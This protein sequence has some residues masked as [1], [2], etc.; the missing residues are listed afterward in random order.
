MVRGNFHLTK[1]DAIIMSPFTVLN[2]PLWADIAVRTARILGYA[3][4]ALT[5]VGALVF[6]P[7]SVTPATVII[8]GSMAI[9]GCVCFVAS[10]WQKYVWEWVSLFFLT[11]GIAVYVVGMWLQVGGNHKY[12]ASASIF[13]MLVMLLVVRLVDLTVYW[14]QNVKAAQLS[15]E[16]MQ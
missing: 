5:G 3:F 12:V 13:S 11:G 8:V 16:I 9:F 7:Q 15:K 4:A 1:D 6:T 2:Y 14:M 10:I